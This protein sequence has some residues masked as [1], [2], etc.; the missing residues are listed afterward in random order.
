MMIM[1]ICNNTIS[2]YVKDER[3]IK[4]NEEICANNRN[5]NLKKRIESCRTYSQRH[6]HTL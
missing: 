3:L 2:K 5:T 6:S 1:I 4:E